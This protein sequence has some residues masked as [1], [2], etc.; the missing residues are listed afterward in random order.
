[1]ANLDTEYF[2]EDIDRAD[3]DL[4]SVIAEDLVH[5]KYIGRIVQILKNY[6]ERRKGESQ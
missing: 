6:N 3:I 5:R 2:T 1:M 4:D